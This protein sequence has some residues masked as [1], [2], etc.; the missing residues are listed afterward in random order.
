LISVFWRQSGR[1]AVL[2][3]LGPVLLAG[4]LVAGCG[5][6]SGASTPT[7][8][9]SRQ[10]LGA[11]GNRTAFIQC[12]R[13]HGVSLPGARPGGFSTRRPGGFPTARPSTFPTARPAGGFG[14]GFPGGFSG[15]F[16]KALK[17]CGAALPNGIPG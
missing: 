1:T 5:A 4:A 13:K 10:A 11:S 6:A 3:T 17:E 16:R 9:A 8:A 14:G 7:P 12:L 15:S 2:R